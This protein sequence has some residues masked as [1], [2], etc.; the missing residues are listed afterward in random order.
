MPFSDRLHHIAVR[1]CLALALCALLSGHGSAQEN[2]TSPPKQTQEQQP[3]TPR[4]P[5]IPADQPEAQPDPEYYK[6]SCDKPKSREDADLCEQ[7]RMAQAAEAAVWW[8]AFQTKL[9]IAGFIA[10]VLSLIFTGWAAWAASVAAKAAMAAVD[11]ER[12]WVTHDGYD[13]GLAI[14]PVID[15][16]RYEKG[17]VIELMWKNTGRSPA[18]HVTVYAA[19]Q[20]VGPNDPVPHFAEKA[21]TDARHAIIGPGARG[22]TALQVSGG[23]VFDRIKRREVQWFVYSKVTYGT[24][25]QPNKRHHTE[26]CALVEVNG[27]RADDQGKM[28]PVIS[29]TPRGAQN[30]AT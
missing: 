14:N 17:F 20:L 9:G 6:A 24:I 5:G 26:F 1:G 4:L 29:L 28:H 11:T 21:A 7:R 23:D 19:N 18:V 10:V 27:E 16:I 13:S 30:A 3:D 22:G 8:A 15:G 2:A 25:S 12:A